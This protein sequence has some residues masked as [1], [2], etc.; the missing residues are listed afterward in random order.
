MG[1]L[2][3]EIPEPGYYSGRVSPREKENNYAGVLL[4][5]RQENH[6]RSGGG[7]EISA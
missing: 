4:V 6:R 5:R 7:L 3:L 1:A 2:L